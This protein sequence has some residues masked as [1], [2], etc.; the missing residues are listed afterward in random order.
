MGFDVRE[1]WSAVGEQIA[2]RPDQNTAAGDRSPYIS[3]LDG[4]V[5]ERFFD[6]LPLAGRSVLEVGCGPG[7]KLRLV[8]SKGPAR[9]VGADLSPVMVELARER[10]AGTGVEVVPL[11]GGPYPFADREFELV[12]TCTVLHHNPSEAIPGILAEIARVSAGDVVLIE[13]TA[14]RERDASAAYHLRPVGFYAEILAEHG[15]ELDSTRPVGTPVSEAMSGWVM[16]LAHSRKLR[17]PPYEEGKPLVPLRL[18]LERALLPVTRRLDRVVPQRAG[19]S[20]M[21]FA[22]R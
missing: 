1:Y 4:R 11:D 18:R 17:R 13:S 3:Y 19:L 22:R 7:G 8:R 5:V 6:R 9:L 15:F 10:L 20:E 16:R 2:A 21:R 12:Y 14:P